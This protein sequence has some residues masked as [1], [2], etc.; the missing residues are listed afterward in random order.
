MLRL[1][2]ALHSVPAMFGPDRDRC[3]EDQKSE[4]LRGVRSRASRLE[5]RGKAM[6]AQLTL[7]IMIRLESNRSDDTGLDT[8]NVV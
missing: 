2:H 6:Q 5:M 3:D 1:E 4:M 8:P 7:P